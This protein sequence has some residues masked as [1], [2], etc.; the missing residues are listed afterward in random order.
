MKENTILQV[1]GNDCYGCGAC[2]NRCP[3]K[4]ISMTY[5]E[6]GFL[7]PQLD[8]DKCIDCGLCAKACPVLSFVPQKRQE[9]ECYAVWA[10]DEIRMKSSSGGMFTLLAEHILDNG[11]YV[12]GAAYT[13][14]YMN[15]EHVVIS[16]KKDLDKLRRSKYVQSNTHN[17]YQEIEFLLKN[18]KTVLFT[19]CPCQV[20]GLYTFLGK[21]YPNLYTADL[22]CHGA[23]SLYAYQSY[24]KELAKGRPIK[25]VDFRDKKVFGWSSSV[26]IQYGNGE[27]SQLPYDNNFWYKGFLSGITTRLNCGHCMFASSIRYGDLSLGDFWQIQKWKPEYND[28]KGTSLVTVNSSKGS[29]LLKNIKKQT[30]LCVEANLDFASQFNGQLRKPQPIHP[31]RR[32]F[33]AHLSKDGYHKAIWYGQKYRYDVGLVGW[34]FAANYGSA[35]TY[36]ALGKILEDW[37]MLAIMIRIPK[38]DGLNWEK[39]TQRTID[40]MSKHFPVSKP[41]PIEK[42]QECNQFCDMF[43][44][45]SDQLWVP[46]Y[47]GLVGHTFFLD[48]VD[49]EKNKVAYATSLG[50]TEYN[51]SNEELMETRRLLERFSAI[52][53]RESTGVSIC[54]EQF[55]LN[56][57]RMLDPVFICDVN[58]YNILADQASIQEAEPYILC[59][60]LDPTSEIQNQI[61]KASERLNMRYIAIT[62][63]KLYEKNRNKWIIGNLKDPTIE[64][65][66]YYFKN[67]AYLITDSHHGLCFGIIYRKN[68]VAFANKSRGVTRF[69]SLVNLLGV[70][71]RLLYDPSKLDK[72]S[73]LETPMDYKKICA[74][75]EKEKETSLIWLK[76]VLS[77]KNKAK[78]SSGSLKDYLFAQI[79]ELSRKYDFL[80]KEIEKLKK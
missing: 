21:D 27:T 45:G 6:E 80:Q 60:I 49:D 20:A 13:D 36:Y 24:I 51:V 26:I 57:S 11:G 1:K 5:N 58:H 73:L 72:S 29:E 54:K 30:K 37:D 59:Y 35:M 78:Q 75:I 28:G 3:Q 76:N 68:L 56:V 67:C 71:E 47:L 12:C 46:N 65:F 77:N 41:R 42:M 50:H 63:M 79:I 15:V 14:D 52:S 25:R 33:F 23:N 7:F 22:I 74:I 38:L 55:G 9:P 4:A 53:V 66:I 31:G 16:N 64:E 62:D 44:I 70:K 39:E 40:F 2:Y 32:F 18:Q 17:V 61:K 34:W 19:G 43:M 10:S 69:E 48:F 8:E